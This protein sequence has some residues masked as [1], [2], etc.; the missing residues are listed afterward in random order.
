M[1]GVASWLAGELPNRGDTWVAAVLD[2]LNSYH[3]ARLAVM[4]A[5]S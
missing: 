4:S 1:G 2:A 5:L 3:E